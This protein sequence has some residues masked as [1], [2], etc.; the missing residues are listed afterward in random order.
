M[1]SKVMRCLFAQMCNFILPGKVFG[2]FGMTFDSILADMG[3]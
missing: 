2:C 1:V 3:C